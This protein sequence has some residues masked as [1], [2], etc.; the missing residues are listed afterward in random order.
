MLQGDSSDFYEK[1]RLSADRINRRSLRRTDSRDIP[2][3]SVPKITPEVLIVS[4]ALRDHGMAHIEG[5][6]SDEYDCC[7]EVA[8]QA[9]EN[10]KKSLLRGK[11]ATIYSPYLNG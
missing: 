9:Y 1:I 10:Y 11:P 6:P 8:I 4:R 3:V 7:A 5:M 2:E